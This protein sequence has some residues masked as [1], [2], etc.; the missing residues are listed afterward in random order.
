[1][2]KESKTQIEVADIFRQFG[3]T[4]RE[5]RKLPIHMHRVMNAIEK[6]RT[7]ELG[8]HVDECDSCGHKKIS[9]NSCRNRHCPK[10]QG[11]AREKWINARKEDLLPVKYFHVV[12]TIPNEI[13]QIA[14]RNQKIIYDILFKAS[15]ETLMELT[16]DNKYLGAETGFI[17]I[18]HTWSQNL[19]DH[20]HIHCIIPGGGLSLDGRHWVHSKKK[21]LLPVKVL[22]RLFRGKFLFYLKEAWQLGKINFAGKINWLSIERQFQN[23]INELYQKEWIV[24]CKQAFKSPMQVIEYLGRYTHRVAISNNRI[25]KIEQGKVTF[26]WKDYKDNNKNKFM[27]IDANEFIRRFLLHILPD[28][29]VKIRHYGLLSNR[30]RK[31]KLKSCQRILGDPLKD[32]ANEAANFGDI[33]SFKLLICP[34]CSN[35]RMVRTELTSIRRRFFEEKK[36]IVK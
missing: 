4:Y 22:S 28:K 36:I 32:A 14:L 18:L 20:P 27:T 2:N 30:N 15:A 1:M 24:Y 6:C 31:T 26:Q 8:G 33:N 3:K 13:N 34:C 5:S 29:F 19:M 23:L 25:I 9:Y 12:F 35:G 10:C 16:R 11:L 7:A 21:F 17:S